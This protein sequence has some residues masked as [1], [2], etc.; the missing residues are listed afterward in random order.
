MDKETFLAPLG[1]EFLFNAVF[2]QE[3]N[4]TALVN[5]PSCDEDKSPGHFQQ[6]LTPPTD[7]EFA[8]H[9]HCDHQLEAI[10]PDA[11]SLVSSALKSAWVGAAVS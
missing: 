5:V 9:L 1:G 2:A 7:F 6:R 3:G 10:W 8:L 11:I 4:H